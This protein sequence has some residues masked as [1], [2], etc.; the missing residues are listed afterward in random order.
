MKQTLG[1]SL[2]LRFRETFNDRQRARP[3]DRGCG[4]RKGY[5]N[6]ERESGGGG[7]VPRG[8]KTGCAKSG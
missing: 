1:G 6:G 7:G 5:G 8:S 3:V 2:E 4:L